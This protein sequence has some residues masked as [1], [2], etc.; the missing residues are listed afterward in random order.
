MTRTLA[1]AAL[2]LAAVATPASAAYDPWDVVDKVLG[3]CMDCVPQVACVSPR[4]PC[5]VDIWIPP[6]P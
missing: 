6:L 2:A 3:S 1:A 5:P 4:P